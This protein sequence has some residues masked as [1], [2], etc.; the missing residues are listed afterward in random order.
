MN[1]RWTIKTEKGMDGSYMHISKWTRLKA[2]HT[3]WFQLEYKI[4]EKVKLYRWWKGQW[5]GLRKE[6]FGIRKE[7]L[8]RGSSGD[9][10]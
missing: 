9:Y 10:F 5:F 3:I 2:L 1:N 6:G 8:N 7:G 4:L